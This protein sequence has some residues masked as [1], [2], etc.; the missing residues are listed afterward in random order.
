MEK[1][2]RILNY[3]RQIYSNDGDF[4][5]T[6]DSVLLA[7]FI[8]INS[9]TKKILDIGTGIGTVPLI[10]SLRVE[11]KIDAVEIQKD[12]ALLCQKN[13]VI[14]KLDEQIRVINE[15]IKDFAVDKNNY[16]DVISCNPPY[17]NGK[18][19]NTTDNIEISKHEKTI[20]LDD[21]LT[22]SKK[23]LKNQG[24][25]FLVYNCDRFIELISKLA[26][27]NLSPKKILFVHYNQHKKASMFLIEAIKNGKQKGNIIMAPLILYDDNGEVTENYKRI[28]SGGFLYE[29]EKL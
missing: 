29:S 2:S 23:V 6:L 22:I 1:K 28:L 13:V 24:K 15:D 12:V 14:N 17:Y 16:Y 26:K 7:N 27:Y 21:I 3:D 11:A 25:L 5:Y 18:N 19:M 8:T 20:N 4:S 10:L 9:S